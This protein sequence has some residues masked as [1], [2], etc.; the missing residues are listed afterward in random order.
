MTTRRAD[1]IPPAVALVG[2]V[3]LLDFGWNAVSDPGSGIAYGL[4]DEP[5]HL[6]TALVLLI[7]LACFLGRRLPAPFIVG[8]LVA[9]VA[10]DLDHL[11]ALLGSN[12]I[13]GAEPRP[14]SHSLLTVV[15]LL[16]GARLARGGARQAAL[17]AAFGVSAHLLRDLAT[18]PGVA[19]F[20]P[21]SAQVVSLPYAAFAATLVLTVGLALRGDSPF[22]RLRL[23]APLACLLLL[24]AAAATAVSAQAARI[25]PGAY[26]PGSDEKPS[27]IQAYGHRV[28]RQ[29]LIL[30]SYKNWSQAPFVGDQLRGVWKRGGVPM[31]T[32]EPWS[33]AGRGIR[34]RAIAHGRYD[35][36]LHRSARTAAAWDHPVFLR[37][38]HEMNGGWY[39]WSR[40]VNGTT[41]A[42][43]RAAWRHLVRI[44]NREGARKVR[45]VWSPYVNVD[46]RHPFRRFFPGGRWIDW[47][48]LDGINWGGSLRW[49]SPGQLF[50]HSYRQ[51]T[52]L[53]SKP[54]MIAETGCGERGGNKPWWVRRMLRRLLP[55]LPHVRAVLFWDV[56]DSRADLRVNSTPSALRAL[57]GAIGARRYR[58]SRVRLLG[59]RRHLGVAARPSG[60]LPAT[61][62]LW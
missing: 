2:L 35:A 45:W 15:V 13:S 26:V 32:W 43:Y 22:R 34:L 7:G 56:A 10:I 60:S 53:T 50:R 48:A 18:G 54:V 16:L 17:G 49:R 55:R 46:G 40:G 6:A 11:P 38:A 20:W 23:A 61:L 59:V 47:V 58:S 12:L 14:Y 62:N 33:K 9:S 29:P 41:P 21:A 24:F 31:V 57:R 52:S 39:P 25:S 5:A 3:F 19:L 30:I 42:I 37:F 36:Y 51:L 27:L 44:F 28:G 4:I 8:A 1:Q